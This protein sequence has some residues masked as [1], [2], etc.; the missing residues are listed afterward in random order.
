MYKYAIERAP[1]THSRDTEGAL[2]VRLDRA[3]PVIRR[4]RARSKIYHKSPHLI[5]EIMID[6]D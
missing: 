6:D 3:E 2:L 5:I 1:R 4:F